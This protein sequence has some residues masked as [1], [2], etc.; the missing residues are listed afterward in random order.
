MVTKRT[1]KPAARRASPK[2][3]RSRSR[4]SST[5]E[6]L[7]KIGRTIPDDDLAKLPRDLVKNFD[8][9]AHGSPRED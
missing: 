6:D 3:A 7:L 9:Y 8:H 1:T 4:G 2:P 5:W